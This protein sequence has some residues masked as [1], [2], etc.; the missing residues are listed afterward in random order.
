MTIC[1]LLTALENMFLS[2]QPDLL[3]MSISED[4]LM[5]GFTS[6]SQF[7]GKSLKDIQT[8]GEI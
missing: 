2:W 1:W 3:T 6:V 5:T 8:E 4:E 7:R